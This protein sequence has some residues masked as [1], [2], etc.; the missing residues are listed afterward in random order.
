MASEIRINVLASEATHNPS[1]TPL[2]VT[3]DM[4]QV[5]P[6]QRF[7]LSRH[8]RGPFT[9]VGAEYEIEGFNHGVLLYTID[10]GDA[11]YDLTTRKYYMVHVQDIP[12]HRDHPCCALCNNAGMRFTDDE[13]E[14]ASGVAGIDNGQ[15]LEVTLQTLQHLVPSMAFQPS[16][17][18]V[19]HHDCLQAAGL[20]KYFQLDDSSDDEPEIVDLTTAASSVTIAASVAAASSVT[21]AASSS[22][23][24]ASS[25]AQ[26][27][28]SSVAQAA[29][30][31][32]LPAN[33]DELRKKRIQRFAPEPEPPIISIR[34]SFEEITESFS[35]EEPEIDPYKYS[36]GN[37]KVF[38][39]IPC[40]YDG[41]NVDTTHGFPCGAPDDAQVDD[42]VEDDQTQVYDDQVEDQA[43]DQ[44]EDQA[45]DDQ[46]QDPDQLQDPSPKRPRCDPYDWMQNNDCH[47]VYP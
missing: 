33:L 42:Q 32:A 19:A 39:M 12:K 34:R 22:V 2:L 18:Y 29:S 11:V 16:N 10:G 38:K 27:A 8:H 13:G 40:T 5:K 4:C 14:Y 9:L 36:G 7:P 25:V 44:V 1:Y 37:R 45:D 41:Y 46:T 17:K 30:S 20:S 21:I 31:S 28:S 43:E 26:A 6:S 24:A 47:D 23:A 35:D 15:L 3:G